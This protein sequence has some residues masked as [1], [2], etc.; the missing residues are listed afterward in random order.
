MAKAVQ[1]ACKACLLESDGYPG[2][3][4]ITPEAA[5]EGIG[6]Y[7]EPDVFDGEAASYIVQNYHTMAANQR[8]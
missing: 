2:E 8:S 3:R 6:Q 1:E 4:N 5:F 7:R